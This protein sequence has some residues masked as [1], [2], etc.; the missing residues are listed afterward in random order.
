MNTKY[1]VLDCPEPVVPMFV[2]DG[3]N[4]TGYYK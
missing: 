1:D 4:S 2:D 3:I